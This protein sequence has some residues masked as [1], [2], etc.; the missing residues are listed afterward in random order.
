MHW[1]RDRPEGRLPIED[2]VRRLSHAP[3]E[4]LGFRDRGLLAP[5]LKA[6]INVID[7][8]NLYLHAPETACDLPGGGQRLLQRSEGYVATIVGGQ[9]VYRHGEATGALPGRL[10]RGALLEAAE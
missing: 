4:L 8:D 7:L 2:L 1:G 10:V 9:I 6:D 5:G 3:A